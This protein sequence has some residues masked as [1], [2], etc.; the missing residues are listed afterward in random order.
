M[1]LDALDSLFFE[2]VIDRDPPPAGVL[3][4]CDV[5]GIAPTDTHFAFSILCRSIIS[6]SADK[7]PHK[8]CRIP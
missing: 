5:L 4:L 7:Q 3:C 8:T 1:F 6:L 2:L